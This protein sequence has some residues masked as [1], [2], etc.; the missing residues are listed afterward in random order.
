VSTFSIGYTLLGDAHF[1][2]V[3]WR[4]REANASQD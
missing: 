4:T 2:A 1:G 3:D